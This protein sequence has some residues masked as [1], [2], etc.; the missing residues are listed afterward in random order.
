MASGIYNVW[1]SHSGEST[2]AQWNSTSVF[3][4]MLLTTAYTFDSDSTAVD[5]TGTTDLRDAE[6]SGTNYVPGY[7]SSDRLSLATR[8]VTLDQTNNLAY[9]DTT[10]IVWSSINVGTVGGLAVILESG[11]SDNTSIPVC[12]FDSTTLSGTTS[13]P[14]TNGGD[15]TV[16]WSTGGVMQSS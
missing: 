6:S 15:F 4:A 13:A 1:K 16:S 14:V 12:F 9:F 2:G 7:Q 11:T 10:D 3:R 5:T 8:T